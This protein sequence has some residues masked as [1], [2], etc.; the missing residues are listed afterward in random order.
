MST[1]DTPVPVEEG[2]EYTVEIAD[3]GEEGDGVA[4]V[5]DFVVLVP[6]AT[7]GERVTV[8]IDEVQE[9]F[10]R[11]AAVKSESDVS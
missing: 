6:D 7:L 9:D 3:T 4:T 8:R 5:Q 1:D 2:E 10:A 11:G